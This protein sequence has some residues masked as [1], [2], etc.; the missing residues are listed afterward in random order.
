MRWILTDEGCVNSAYV[1]KIVR[2][3]D[4]SV[5]H[6][7]DGTTARSSLQFD[8]IGDQLIPIEPLDDDD[9]SAIPF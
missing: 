1:I 3:S 2:D 4:G 5:L 7:R 9:E 8:V 6:L